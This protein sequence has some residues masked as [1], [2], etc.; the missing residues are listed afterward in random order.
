MAVVSGY[1]SLDQI[2]CQF[3]VGIPKGKVLT[4]KCFTTQIPKIH[5]EP[6]GKGSNNEL[7][8]LQ[9]GNNVGAE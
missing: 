6:P 7:R 3:S 1:N 2:E 9:T 8:T 4:L 5:L